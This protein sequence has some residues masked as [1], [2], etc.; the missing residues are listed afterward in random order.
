MQE[1]GGKGRSRIVPGTAV[2]RCRINFSDP[3]KEVERP[4]VRDGTPRTRSSPIPP[5][6][7]R[8]RWRS[9]APAISDP[10]LLRPRRASRRPRTSCTGIAG[11]E[12]PNTTW[13]FDLDKASQTLDAAGWALDGDTR[14]K[15]DVELKIVYT[16]TRSTRSARRR[17][18]STSRTGRRPASRSSSSRSTPGSSSTAR[19]A[20]TRTSTTSTATCDVHQQSVRDLPALLHAAA[21]TRATTATTSPRRRTAGRRERVRYN[22]P[23]YDALYDQ[24]AQRDRSEPRRPSSSSR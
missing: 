22:N 24:A 11:V 17:R 8:S 23:D 10:V 12:S 2:E 15:G 19:P 16:T 4:E 14:K 20:T 7:R 6:A 21:G 1:E 13:E 9:T 18:P 3:N 5:S